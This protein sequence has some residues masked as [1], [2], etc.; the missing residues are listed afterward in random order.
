MS[1]NALRIPAKFFA[2]GALLSILTC[3][4]SN[5]PIASNASSSNSSTCICGS[6]TA[7]CPVQPGPEFVYAAAIT[8][9]GGQP[10]PSLKCGRSATPEHSSAG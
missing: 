10:D 3:C 7:A 1:A 2:V 6:G 5:S 8:S 4:G 9:T